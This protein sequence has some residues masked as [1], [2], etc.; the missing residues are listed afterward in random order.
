MKTKISIFALLCIVFGGGTFFGYQLHNIPLSEE[1]IL[2]TTLRDTNESYNFIDPLLAC[3]VGVNS[4]TSS[5]NELQNELNELV[6]KNIANK[7]IESA[8]IYVRTLERGA[9]TGIDPNTGYTP[10]SLMK[11]PVLI[12]YLKQSEYNPD[13]LA[14]RITITEDPTPNTE[15]DIEPEASIV[16]GNTY[17]V[18]E[19]LSLMIVHSD[20][21]ALNVLMD[22]LDFSVLEESFTDLGITIPEDAVSYE[23]NPRLYSRFFRVLYNATYLSREN[24]EKAL[25]LLN[26]SA[27]VDGIRG[28]I[29]ED[30]HVS[31]KFGEASATLTTGEVGHDLHD[32]G[33][34][35]AKEPYAVCI[36]TKG[37][38]VDALGDFLQ[39]TSN[40][41]YQ[42]LGKN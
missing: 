23:I 18:D 27:F 41:I 11:V 3:N 16:V 24:S 20:N 2:G 40:L 34:V 36:M 7:N 32:C 12:A 21:R 31:H 17:T 35:Y 8:S 9:W 29:P 5:L 25:R 38:R 42:E 15:Q 33:I 37:S 14:Y 10:A 19:L 22:Y 28:G 13:L 4:P 39:E 30:V 1:D 26:D 6:E